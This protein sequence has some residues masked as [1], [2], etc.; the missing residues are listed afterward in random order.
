MMPGKRRR[1]LIITDNHYISAVLFHG[2]GL[3][4]WYD[5]PE[6]QRTA[7]HR[8]I[9][10]RKVNALVTQGETEGFTE[11]EV[12][13]AFPVHFMDLCEN[14]R[15]IRGVDRLL[16]ER[17]YSGA[18]FLREPFKG[19]KRQPRYACIRRM[20]LGG[21]PVDE[22]DLLVWFLS[23]NGVPVVYSEAKSKAFLAKS[24][25]RFV[26]QAVTVP[27]ARRKNRTFAIDVARKIPLDKAEYYPGVTL[28]GDHRIQA[29]VGSAEHALEIYKYVG[30]LIQA[31]GQFKKEA[32]K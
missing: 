30:L 23:E 27:A 3:P 16:P 11:F 12:H 17:K 31:T 7:R 32:V 9:M 10:A 24:G 20:A 26:E 22:T 14:V 6:V 13:E 29:N 1:L 19:L 28:H 15:V 25:G 5:L 8:K 21:K 2:F 4:P 18:A